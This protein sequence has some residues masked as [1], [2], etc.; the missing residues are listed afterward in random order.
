[1]PRAASPAA[2][3]VKRRKPGLTALRCFSQRLPDGQIT[4]ITQF[5]VESFILLAAK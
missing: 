2:C 5:P 3:A 1:M 4:F